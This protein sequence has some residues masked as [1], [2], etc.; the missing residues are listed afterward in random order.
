MQGIAVVGLLLVLLCLVLAVG[1][2]L[3]PRLKIYKKEKSRTRGFLRW[4]AYAVV[5]FIGVSFI[6]GK[7]GGNDSLP[8]TKDQEQQEAQIK[9][10]AAEQQRVDAEQK[11]Q[12]DEQNRLQEASERKKKEELAQVEKQ[13]EAEKSAEVKQIKKIRGIS[14]KIFDV[15]VTRLDGGKRWDLFIKQESVFSRVVY[16]VGLT[17]ESIAKGMVQDKL[18]SPSD[19]FLFFVEVPTVDKYGQSNSLLGMKIAWSG[20]DLLKINW[21][22]MFPPQ[23]L[24]LASS[25][26]L[27]PVLRGDVINLARDPEAAA[28]YKDFLIKALSR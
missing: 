13:R 25:V 14:S 22:Q 21:R 27:R 24:N 1:S 6:V 2:L 19:S 4:L 11:K 7:N 9:Q 18:V 28:E 8:L 20:E 10:Q 15:T 26:E 12:R 3:F 23:F 16:E 17:L 5:I